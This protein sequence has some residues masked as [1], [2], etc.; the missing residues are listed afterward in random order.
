VRAADADLPT[1][2]IRTMKDVV[3]AATAPKRFSMQL[4]GAFALLALLLAAIGI[5][6][7]TAY[8]VNQRTRE[9]GIRVALGAT[10]RS[11]LR[12]IVGYALTL[13][14]GGVLVGFAAA[15]VIIP[16]MKD[17][18]F[19]V[20]PTDPT[21]FIVITTVLVATAVVAAFTPARR[22]ARVDPMH[23]LRAD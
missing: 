11:V 17:M 13:A 1:F 16:L 19:D 6:G 18:L 8:L 2:A 9:I 3:A 10:P 7:M 22:A 5:Y 15:L 14:G 12:L 21:T 23:A 20:S 4:L